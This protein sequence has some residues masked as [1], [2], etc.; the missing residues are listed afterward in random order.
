MGTTDINKL[1]SS[2]FDVLDDFDLEDTYNHMVKFGLCIYILK[3]KIKSLIARN[4]DNNIIEEV[5]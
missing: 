2:I 5:I 1:N 4:I 3:E